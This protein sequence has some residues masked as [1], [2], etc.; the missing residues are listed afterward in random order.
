MGYAD[1]TK[2]SDNAQTKEWLNQFSG[3]EK[4][5]ATSFVDQ[6]LRVS[7]NSLVSG[8]QSLLQ[9]ISPEN[10]KFRESI[11]LFA[12][13]EI[14]KTYGKIPP[15]FENTDR[16]RAAGHGA[17]PIMVNPNRQEVGSEGIIA[18]IITDY[19]RQNGETFISHPGPSKMRKKKVRQI[20]ILTD[21]IGSGQRVVTMLDSLNLVATLRSWRS[22]HLIRFVI[23]AYSGTSNG[24]NVVKS[25]K[26]HPVVK[27]FIGC[28]TIVNSFTGALL[29]KIISLCKTYP[30]GHSDPLGYKN[31]GAL[32]AFAHGCPNNVPPIIHSK[33]NRWI[34][35]FPGRSTTSCFSAF[36]D[37]GDYGEVSNRDLNILNAQRALNC[38]DG[39]NWIY[40]MLILAVST[41][42]QNFQTIS[43]QTRIPLVD[44][45]RVVTLAKEA[46]WLDHAMRL[47]RLG[48]MELERLRRRRKKSPIRLAIGENE[49]YYPTGLRGL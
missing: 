10:I 4:E 32:I 48:R 18:N 38:D 19:C 8:L 23:I 44:V 26:L 30:E 39:K 13:R 42:S 22:Y 21:F 7:R 43:A 5:V 33:K 25:H 17:P 9:T 31:G 41:H 6:I 2:L 20:V 40:A 15:Y 14:I 24:I 29:N 28:P 27:T 34:P 49:L 36:S 16:G 47:T 46:L 11:A 1:M 37:I 45:E 35:L 12:E 3:N